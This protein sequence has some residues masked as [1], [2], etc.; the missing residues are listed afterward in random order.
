MSLR[1]LQLALISVSVAIL[2]AG[3]VYSD[4][5]RLV[6]EV[7]KSDL[8]Y[9]FYAFV[10]SNIAIILRVAKWKVL[11]G[12]VRFRDLIPV[13]LLGVTVSNFSPGKAA[14]PTKALILKMKSRISVSESLRSIIW[15]RVL[16]ILVL[17]FLAFAVLQVLSLSGKFLFLSILSLIGFVLIISVVLTGL[18]RKE[19]GYRFFHLLRR[20]PLLNRIDSNFIENF[21]RQRIT[22]K[23]ISLSGVLTLFAWILDGFV[24]SFSFRS[25]GVSLDP[26]LLAGLVALATLVGIISF[27]PGG[28]G[29][30]ELVMLFLLGILGIESPLGL[31]GIL[32][33][34]FLSIWYVAFLGC[35]SFIHLSR[36]MDMRNVLG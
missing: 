4:P 3:V 20:L 2:V 8:N 1:K 31:S 25:I 14:E 26:F 36:K 27:L 5:I 32:L 33:S 6:S 35:L 17:L 15:E 22:L 10:F 30:M 23:K 34:R 24:F 12:D 19:M 16:D 18:M 11:L 7:S 29:S 28:L 21:Y 13:Q 9:I